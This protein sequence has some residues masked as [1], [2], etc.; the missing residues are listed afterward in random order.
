MKDRAE[1]NRRCIKFLHYG[2]DFPPWD[3]VIVE[4]NLPKHQGRLPSKV[5]R[6][7]ARLPCCDSEQRIFYPHAHT[8]ADIPFIAI[9]R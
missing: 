1:I 4:V 7:G 3:M 2:L 8:A 9:P 5:A 6:D